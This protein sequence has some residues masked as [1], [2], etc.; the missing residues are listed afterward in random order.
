[1]ASKARHGKGRGVK[2]EGL[3]GGTETDEVW[4]DLWALDALEILAAGKGKKEYRVRF[5]TG[6]KES[7]GVAPVAYMNLIGDKGMSGERPLS[8]ATFLPPPDAKRAA[9]RLGPDRRRQLSLTQEEGATAGNLLGPGRYA[10]QKTNASGCYRCDVSSYSFA[11]LRSAYIRAP[12]QLFVLFVLTDI[13][14][15]AVHV[16]HLVTG[17]GSVG[18]TLHTHRERHKWQL[19]SGEVCLLAAEGRGGGRARQGGVG[20]YGCVFAPTRTERARGSPVLP[21]ESRQ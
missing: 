18:G 21:I 8:Y 11:R 15:Q 3:D 20:R 4:E 5:Y 7:D 1:M 19:V 2:R 9:M 14:C 17:S 16:F 13:R 6:D 12:H 10:S